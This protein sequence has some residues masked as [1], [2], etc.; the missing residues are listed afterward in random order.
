MDNETI[1]A[2]MDCINEHRRDAKVNQDIADNGLT[3]FFAYY[4][5]REARARH[6]Q[7][8]ARHRRHAELLEAHL[9]EFTEPYS[10][11]E[12]PAEMYTWHRTPQLQRRTK[13]KSFWHKLT[14]GI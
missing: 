11:I 1:D 6:A 13:R 2:L 3:G 14:R 7:I 10:C 4:V 5:D 12:V 9:R 8:A